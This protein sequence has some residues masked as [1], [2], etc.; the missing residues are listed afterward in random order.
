MNDVEKDDTAQGNQEGERCSEFWT[1]FP[2]DLAN[3]AVL[4]PEV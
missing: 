2:L 4:L 3:A 1:F